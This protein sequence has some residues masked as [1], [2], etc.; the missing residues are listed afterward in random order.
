MGWQDGTPIAQSS[1]A[2]PAWQTGTPIENQQP[3]LN[4][5]QK[6]I[7]GVNKPIIDAADMIISPLS[8]GARVIDQGLADLFGFGPSPAEQRG[9][10]DI[11]FKDAAVSAGIV[12]PDDTPD[13]VAGRA[14]EGAGLAASFLLPFGAA[15]KMAPAAQTAATQTQMGGTVSNAIRNMLSTANTTMLKNPKTAAAVEAALGGTAGAGGYLAEQAYPES[16]SA[17]MMGEL[18][19]GAAPVMGPQ[20]AKA[21]TSVM[22]GP[23]IVKGVADSLGQWFGK[24]GAEKRAANRMGRATDDIEAALTAL[25]TPSETVPGLTPAQKTDDP[26]LLALEKSVMNSSDELLRKGDK[27]LSELNKTIQGEIEDVGTGTPVEATRQAFEQQQS[28]LIKQMD[29]NVDAA[30]AEAQKKLDSVTP[31]MSR[32][33]SNI[34]ASETLERSKRRWRKAETKLYNKI[35]EDTAAP[36]SKSEDTYKS[37]SD[38]LSVSERVD[39]PVEAKERL[40]PESELYFGK[41]G[42]DTTIKELRGL[43]SKLRE[44]ARIARSNGEANK[45]R[46]ADKIAT[47]INDDLSNMTGDP[48]IMQDIKRATAFSRRLNEKF[49]Q[50]TVGKILSK[51]KQGDRT[52]E[53]SLTLEKSIGG[54][55]PKARQAYDDILNAAKSSDMKESVDTYLKHRFFNDAMK[56]GKVDKGKADKFIKNNGELLN[57]IPGLKKQFEDAITS[58]KIAALQKGRADS[59]ANRMGNPNLSK[60]ALFIQ[61]EPEKAFEGLMKSRTPEQDTQKLINLARRDTTGEAER[62]LKSGF[63]GHLLSKS[64]SSRTDIDDEFY[65]SGKNLKK[66]LDEHEPIVKRLFT[67]QEQARIKKIQESAIRLDLRLASDKTKEGVLGDEPNMLLSALS[68]MSG[69]QAGRWIAKYTGGGTVQTPGIAANFLRRTVRSVMTDKASNLITEAIQDEELFRALLMKSIELKNPQKKFIKQRLNAWA[70]NLLD[71]SGLDEAEEAP[72]EV[73]APSPKQKRIESLKTLRKN[74]SG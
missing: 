32:E 15:A 37:L 27:Q 71:E 9:T 60:A 64:K 50:G 29:K 39:M 20:L 45:A 6:F 16:E 53:E 40:N 36:F 42:A 41:A 56:D 49:T 19:G 62:G 7:Q 10:D 59:L 22:P 34:Q 52:V 61:K 43:Q 26:G 28:A 68:G 17:R 21:A 18:A 55:G 57:R 31:G 38:E 72:E 69:S 14:G 65:I 8:R 54:T 1:Q 12:A 58:G 4:I 73:K 30:M 35:P 33:Q 23:A 51:K 48:E 3:E 13:S 63:M 2:V 44:S 25:N 47:S 5:A 46:I 67:K 66:F 24:A 74:I 70:A 11:S